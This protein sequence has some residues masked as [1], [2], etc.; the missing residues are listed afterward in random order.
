[1]GSDRAFLPHPWGAERSWGAGQSGEGAEIGFV[2]LIL[3]LPEKLI[4][5]NWCGGRG[6]GLNSFLPGAELDGWTGEKLA[7]RPQLGV[8]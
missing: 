4:L 7:A 1:M 5:K 2:S 8:R 6:R 3:S